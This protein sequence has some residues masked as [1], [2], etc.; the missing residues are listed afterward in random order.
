MTAP[1]PPPEL[2]ELR[3][4]IRAAG[5]RVT[6]GRVAVYQAVRASEA[7]LSHAEIAR[8]LSPGGFDR[9][10]IYRNLRDLEKAGL[11]SRS[12]LGDH[13]WRYEA[14][15]AA[16][17]EGGHPHFVCTDCGDVACLPTVQVTITA[18][19]EAPVAAT[20]QRVEVQLRGVC[21]RCT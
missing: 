17:H 8:A 11:V 10:A 3:D 21:D 14:A 6:S 15:G 2:A 1:G 13:V 7:P 12:D 16:G 20:S 9:A 19:P 5:L 4:L 18:S